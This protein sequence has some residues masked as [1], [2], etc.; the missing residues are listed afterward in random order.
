LGDRPTTYVEIIQREGT[1]GFGT[2]NVRHL[3][4]EVVREQDLLDT[5]R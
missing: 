1:L 2:D 3:Y 5:S 4:S